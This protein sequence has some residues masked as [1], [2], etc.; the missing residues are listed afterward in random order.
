MVNGSLSST[1][2]S[3]IE[4]KLYS[5]SKTQIKTPPQLLQNNGGEESLLKAVIKP[6]A[7]SVIILRSS[8]R[9]VGAGVERSGRFHYRFH[10]AEHL[11]RRFVHLFVRFNHP[12]TDRRRCAAMLQMLQIFLLNWSHMVTRPSRRPR[13]SWRVDLRFPHPLR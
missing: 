9:Y 8:F 11:C 5:C 13:A 2:A 10:Q 7:A 12:S 6:H 1:G 3:T 4:A